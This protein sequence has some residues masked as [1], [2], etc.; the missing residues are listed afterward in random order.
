MKEYENDYNLDISVTII[1]NINDGII[2]TNTNGK[3]N[4]IN[5]IAQDIL[6]ID[7]HYGI[8]RIISDLIPEVLEFQLPKRNYKKTNKNIKLGKK[9][10]LITRV[11]MIENNEI[12]EV[13]YVFKDITEKES[14]KNELISEKNWNDIL[15]QA[16]NMAYE[17]IVIVDKNG[18]ITMI[19]KGYAEFLGIDD[20]KVIGKHATD[21]IENTRMHIVVKTGKEEEAQLQKI[22]NKYMMATRTPLFING[23]IQGAV[24]KVL[25]KN[26]KELEFLHKKFSK[27]QKELEAYKEQFQEKNS[28][29]YT[30][31]DIVGNSDG[32]MEA[33]KLS[34]KAA[35]TDSN[36]LLI[37]ESGTGKELFAHSIH[38]NSNRK[39]GPFVKVNCGAIPSDLLE[40]EL[41]GY[42]GGAFT[43]AKKEGKIGKF[44]LADGG[45]IFLDEIGDM[46]LHMQVKLL[47]VL[48][49][50][51]VERVGG[52]SPKNIDIRIIAATNQKLDSMVKEGKFRADL[53]YRLNVVTVRI[54]PL[55][56]R[57]DD[58]ILLSK[59]LC[60]KISKKLNREKCIVSNEAL[61]YMKGYKW[62]GNIR[63][64]ENA[65]ERAINIM[66][67]TN[68]LL[69][70]KHLPKEITG[71]E[72]DFDI[73]KLEDAIWQAERN[74]IINAIKMCKG[75]KQKA[76]KELGISRTTLYEKVNKYK[77]L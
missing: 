65:I 12:K 55:R 58:I 60:D 16:L 51:E 72:I 4:I 25:F 7:E 66:E 76:A 1:N 2:V 5:K 43:G 67:N 14:I 17:G 53:Y 56:E 40:S 19:S 38:K 30:F 10:I 18:Y 42:E 39:Y 22:G 37:G 59:F 3:I 24:G 44:E 8:G 48:Q 49:E 64:L 33:K 9:V 68:N 50:K 73:L 31:A 29:R 47:R 77:I 70:P 28:A 63:Q 74:A 34:K 61:E 21:V 20:K 45:T 46:P 52:V 6:N 75:N 15:K 11:P 71:V 27:V 54:P 23:E 36:V 26:A 13:I 35:L 62:E 41:F 69:L 32:I 57:K